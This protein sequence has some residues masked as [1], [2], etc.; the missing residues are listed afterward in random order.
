MLLDWVFC[1]TKGKELKQINI[2]HTQEG[3]SYRV[4]QK[5]GK[6]RR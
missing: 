4:G 6:W 1:V 3:S 2:D 5:D